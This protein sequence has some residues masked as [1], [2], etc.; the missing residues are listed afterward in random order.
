MMWGDK[1]Y[2]SLNYELR[3]TFGTKVIKLSLD[4]GFTC[5]NRDGTIGNRGCIFCGEE[6][7][8]EFT[9]SRKLSIKDQIE[10]QKRFLSKKWS[11]GKYISFF[12]NFTNT[13]STVKDLNKKYSE[14]I[15][16]NGVVGLAIATRPDCLSEEVLKLLEEFNKKTFLWVELGL[17]TIHGETAKFIRRGYELDCYEKAIMEL[18]KR[19]VKVV[20][21]LIFGL[22]NETNKDMLDSVKYISNTNTWGVK[23]HNLYIQEGTDLYNYYIKNPFHIL[24]IDEYISL[25]VDSIELL[26]QN[27]VVHR[28]TGDGKKELLVEPRWT[29][30]KLKVL[31]SIDKELKQRNTYQGIYY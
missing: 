3:K 26:P 29:L 16:Q 11:E 2:L 7:S 18:N 19:N 25:V 8:G 17:Q 13:Y 24:S 22:P 5:P 27:M 30:N 9:S 21:H 20:T 28:L 1:R 14:A 10:S 31:S 12:Q 23:F 4:G 15:S 6:G